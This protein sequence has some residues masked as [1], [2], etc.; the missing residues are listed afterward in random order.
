MDGC[1][2]VNARDSE[3]CIL[4]RYLLLQ[5]SIR[6]IMRRIIDELIRSSEGV[7]MRLVSSLI[8]CTELLMTNTPTT[9]LLSLFKLGTYL[10]ACL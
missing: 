10:S 9:T 3:T 5:R 7:M 1:Q 2:V 6:E 8:P 4:C